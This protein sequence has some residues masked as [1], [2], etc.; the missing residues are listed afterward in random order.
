MVGLSRRF[1]RRSHQGG[2]LDRYGDWVR[3]AAVALKLGYDPVKYLSLEGMER[4]VMEL[5][6]DE[7]ARMYAREE[8][9]RLMQMQNAVQAGIARAF[10]G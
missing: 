9:G 1:S 7:A 3:T 6:L 4:T 5:I 2:I 8:E 10:G